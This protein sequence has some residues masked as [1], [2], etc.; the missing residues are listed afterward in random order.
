MNCPW[1]GNES[2]QEKLCSGCRNKAVGLGKLSDDEL[3]ALPYGAIRIDRE[4]TVLSVNP[5]ET[6]MSGSGAAHYLG[7]NFFRDVAP[8]ADVHAFAGRFKDFLDSAVPLEEFNF[9][10]K[11]SRGDIAV[12]ITFV[13]DENGALLIISKEIR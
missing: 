5:A 13:R 3:R 6:T 11:F 12:R 1:C 4:G 7:R 10:Y 2:D 9:L 8:C